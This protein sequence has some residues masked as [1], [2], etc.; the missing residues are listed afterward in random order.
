MIGGKGVSKFFKILEN[1][2]QRICALEGKREIKLKN[3]AKTWYKSGSTIEKIV[4]LIDDGFFNIPH[5]IT[6]II[7]ELKTKDYHLKASDLTLPLR[8]IVRKELLKRTKKGTDGSIS[9]TWLYVKK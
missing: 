6:E 9:N 3:K 8:R 4:L 1:H 7:L 2:E 5:T